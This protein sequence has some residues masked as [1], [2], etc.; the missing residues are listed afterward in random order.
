MTIMR[1]CVFVSS[2]IFSAIVCASANN[3][4]S[5]ELVISAKV[6]ILA[7]YSDIR[8]HDSPWDGGVVRKLVTRYKNPGVDRTVYFEDQTYPIKIKANHDMTLKLKTPEGTANEAFIYKEGAKCTPSAD[9]P[10][11]R[12]F[13]LSWTPEGGSKTELSF[14]SSKGVLVHTPVGLKTNNGRTDHT[15][16]QYK[17]HSLNFSSPIPAQSKNLLPGD[18]SSDQIQFIFMEKV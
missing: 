11:C 10:T 1:L 15:Q 3:D 14:N 4:T 8:F 2:F 12:R 9:S 6:P 5:T 17:T 18:Y 13:K 16:E 7:A